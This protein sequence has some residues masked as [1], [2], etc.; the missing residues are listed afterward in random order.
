MTAQ[1]QLV[2]GWTPYHKLTP[3]DQEVFKE[4]LVGFVGV[5]YEPEEVSS[6]VVHGT[7]YRYLSKAAL[8]GSTASWKAI[9]EVY[10]PIEGRPHITQIHRI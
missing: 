7:N 1:E 3:K 6:Q 10:A 4:A 5:S 9:V 8:P 2:G